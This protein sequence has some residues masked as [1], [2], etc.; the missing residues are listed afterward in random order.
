MDWTRTGTHCTAWATP[1]HASVTPFGTKSRIERQGRA[2]FC[3]SVSFGII[4]IP[5]PCDNE[6]LFGMWRRCEGDCKHKPRVSRGIKGV[7]SREAECSS[8]IK[9]DH[10]DPV[11][12]D[13]LAQEE[14]EH[15]TSSELPEPWVNPTF[16]VNSADPDLFI[17]AGWGLFGSASCVLGLP[18][19]L[20]G[21]FV[22]RSQ[23]L[24]ASY[25]RTP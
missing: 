5:W 17:S 1:G 19:R 10:C 15:S 2:P 21:G 14:Y 24:R 6:P 25:W 11:E 16:K 7:S 9:L 20:W 8:P 13:G 18:C 23:S 3:S 12:M 22:L 4:S